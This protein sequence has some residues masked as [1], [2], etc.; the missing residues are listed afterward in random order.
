MQ[1][2]NVYI[3]RYETSGKFWPIVHSSTI[4]SLVLMHIIA[5]G[6]FGLKNLPLASGLM[7]PLPVLTLLFNQ[8]CQKRFVPLFKAYPAEVR[9]KNCMDLYVLSSN[10]ICYVL[11][12]ELI[13]D[14]SLR[15]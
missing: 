15:A 3:C 11:K 14:L 7:V 2:L 13:L 1:L 5:I 8:Y 12:L 9:N 6:I 4:F 10:F